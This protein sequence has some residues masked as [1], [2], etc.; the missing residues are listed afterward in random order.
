MTEGLSS[1]RFNLQFSLQLHSFT[2]SS[3]HSSTKHRSSFLKHTRTS[4]RTAQVWPKRPATCT[5]P[6]LKYNLNKAQRA[7]ISSLF[8]ENQP[9]TRS[10]RGGESSEEKDV[11]PGRKRSEV[12]PLRNAACNR[13]TNWSCEKCSQFRITREWFLLF[14]S[15]HNTLPTV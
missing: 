15:I 7:E 2:A 11:L 5:R 8:W 1:A 9:Q 10:S 6:L 13:K 3:L 4:G 14:N 12:R